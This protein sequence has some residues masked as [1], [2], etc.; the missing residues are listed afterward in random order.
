M[1]Y[2]TKKNENA[3]V[4][5]TVTYDSDEVEAAYRN[6]YRKAARKVKIPGFRAGK[7][8]IELLEKHLGDSVADDAAKLLISDSLHDL[9]ENLDPHPVT[10]PK[11]EITAFDRKKGATYEGIY[12]TLPEVKPG[13]YKKIKGTLDEVAISDEDLSGEIEH[14][15]KNHAV[16]RSREGEPS[17]DGDRI[18]LDLEI[19]EGQKRLFQKK[20][21]HFRVGE[22]VFPGLDEHLKG[23]HDGEEKGYTITVPLEFPD[24]LY[25]GKEVQVSFTVHQVTYAD[26]PELNDDFAKEV[27]PYETFDELKQSLR[28]EMKKEADRVLKGRC[29]D[30]IVGQIVV[31]SKIVIPESF[32]EKDISERIEQMKSRIEKKDATVEE[33]ARLM[34]LSLEK[35]HAELRSVS[36]ESLK[37]NLLLS[38]IAKRE[39]IAV[40]TED[41][42]KEMSQRWN[43][44]EDQIDKLVENGAIREEI[45]G[46]LLY[47][48]CVDFLF[49]NGEIKKGAAVP[50]SSLNEPVD[51]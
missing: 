46:R 40:S 19:K 2:K 7:A 11:F 33:L 32:I 35:F 5:L 23:V 37:K 39:S 51:Q 15:Q 25:A 50:Y 21:L 31:D 38:E 36:E 49:Q 9:V 4:Q 44:P 17:E 29:I 22:A 45:E 8:P 6:A 12:E 30:S 41:V 47:S 13:K 24:P 1:E 18:N 10:L 28:D 16:M 26:L 3:T 34:G 42:K 43:L 20:D 48:A 27:G 14:L